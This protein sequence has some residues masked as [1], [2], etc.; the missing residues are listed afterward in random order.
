MGR[1]EFEKSKADVL[2]ILGETIGLSKKELED[3]GKEVG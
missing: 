2:A 1:E 3:K